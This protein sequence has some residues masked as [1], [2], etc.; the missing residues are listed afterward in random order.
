M[1]DYC[2]ECTASHACLASSL[3]GGREGDGAL[4]PTGKGAAIM[5][6]ADQLIRLH[7]LVQPRL[8]DQTASLRR[9]SM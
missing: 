4:N 8:L 6:H 9:V 7:Q 5:H 1:Q 3:E 2:A